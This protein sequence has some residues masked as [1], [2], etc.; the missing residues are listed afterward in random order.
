M[1]AYNLT[2]KE[3]IVGMPANRFENAIEYKLETFNGFK[4][5]YAEIGY[6]NVLTQ[7][8]VAEGSDYLAP[9]KGYGLLNF[10]TGFS[11]PTYKQQQIIVDFEISNLL[12]TAYRDYLNRFRYY[13]DEMGR[14]YSLKL[15]MTF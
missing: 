12:N 11:L 3:G 2:L 8:N 4:D 5:V 9:P 1:R 15:K 7:D 14:N 13:A 6:Q 10:K